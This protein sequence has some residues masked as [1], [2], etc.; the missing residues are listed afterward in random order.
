MNIGNF[1]TSEGRMVLSNAE[2]QTRWR[3][4]HPELAK[5][6]TRQWIRTERERTEKRV[7]EWLAKGLAKSRNGNS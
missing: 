1:G 5:E 7:R 4:N 2:R 6:R 3:L